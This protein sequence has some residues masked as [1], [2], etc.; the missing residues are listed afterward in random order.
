MRLDRVMFHVLWPP[1]AI[2]ALASTLSAQQP[3][4]VADSVDLNRYAGK[5]Y[6][7]ARIPNKFQDR[8]AGD[9][10]AQYTLRADSRIDVVNQCRNAEGGIVQ[11]R[12]IARKGKSGNNAVLQV[13][14]AP[15]ILS[16][17]PKVWGD[18]WILAIGPDYTWSV[19]GTPSRDYLWILSRAPVM[20]ANGYAQ[21][22]EIAKGNGF[23]TSRVV[24]T[25]Q[26]N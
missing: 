6:E 25:P 9:V 18:Y 13:R 2:V 26:K 8:C 3:L 14:F 7:I 4:R 21:A 19:V 20:S 11:A 24:K 15:A 5:W 1:L 10:V 22:I 12:G 16:F 23:D 17:L